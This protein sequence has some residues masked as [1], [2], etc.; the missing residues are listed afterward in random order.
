M[1]QEQ[2][3]VSSFAP[4]LDEFAR[5]GQLKNAYH[6]ALFVAE[7][8]GWSQLDRRKLIGLSKQVFDEANR[9]FPTYKWDALK[10]HITN[11]EMFTRMI[12]EAPLNEV[13]LYLPAF[14]DASHQYLQELNRELQAA[15]AGFKVKEEI[16]S[17]DL[18]AQIFEIKPYWKNGY[19]LTISWQMWI[20]AKFLHERLGYKNDNSFIVDARLGKGKSSFTLALATTLSEFNGVAFTCANNVFFNEKREF[21]FDKIRH[22]AKFGD[23]YVYD[24]AGNQV[25]KKTWWLES[26]VELMNQGNLDRF[27]G[28]SQFYLWDSSKNLDIQLRDFRVHGVITIPERGTAI[29]KV[30]NLNPAAKTAYTSNKQGDNEV[31]LSSKQYKEFIDNFD[32]NKIF[33]IPFYNIDDSKIWK[34]DYLPTKT[35][36]F[37]NKRMVKIRGNWRPGKSG[38]N[39]ESMM[40]GLLMAQAPDKMALS[41]KDV[42]DYGKQINYNISYKKLLNFLHE[43]TGVKTSDLVD[44]PGHIKVQKFSQVNLDNEY[45]RRYIKKLHETQ[46]EEVDK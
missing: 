8:N 25:N 31:V 46:P 3:V 41:F 15:G 45:V 17:V 2:Q 14:S 13:G 22:D 38:R 37:R 5:L 4:F 11:M 36:S 7:Q 32:R 20:F 12:E 6:D 23:I 35:D 18:L 28:L 10:L 29:V 30:P 33:E 40:K 26:Q 19:G 42:E 44:Y 16:S 1:P 27:M 9:L 43:K 39:A 24:E 34:D 21:I